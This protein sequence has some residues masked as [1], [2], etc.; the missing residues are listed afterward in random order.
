MSDTDFWLT[1]GPFSWLEPHLPQNIRGKVPLMTGWSSAAPCMCWN[2]G[3]V[4]R[5]RR[6]PMVPAKRG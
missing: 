6:R 1:A 4:G 3:A 2:R 5:M